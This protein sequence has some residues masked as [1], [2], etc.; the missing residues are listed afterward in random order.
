MDSVT[1]WREKCNS[2]AEQVDQLQNDLLTLERKNELLEKQLDQR[3]P[4]SSQI[5]KGRKRKSETDSVLNGSERPS[6]ARRVTTAAD[7]T[8]SDCLTSD[9]FDRDFKPFEGVYQKIF[10]PHEA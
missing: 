8:S 6:K 10:D 4:V 1:L 5:S 7:L 3:P 2:Y 9:N